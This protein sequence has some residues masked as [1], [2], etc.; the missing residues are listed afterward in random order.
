MSQSVTPMPPTLWRVHGHDLRKCTI[1]IFTCCFVILTFCLYVPFWKSI[2]SSPDLTFNLIYLQNIL[3]CCYGNQYYYIDMLLVLL[4]AP[5]HQ[6]LKQTK[7]MKNF[8]MYFFNKIRWDKKRTNGFVQCC[9]KQPAVLHEPM[10]Q[11]PP[12]LAKAQQNGRG[13]WIYKW[14]LYH[15]ILRFT[16]TEATTELY[17]AIAQQSQLTKVTILHSYCV[18]Y[19]RRIWG[20]STTMPCYGGEITAS[21]LTWTLKGPW[22]K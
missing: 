18:F 8:K 9:K 17:S 15:R 22:D 20:I 16:S 1:K 7:Y 2:W 12:N 6:N 5:H 3:N 19:L 10:W 4:C 13:V 21:N 11:C 14:P